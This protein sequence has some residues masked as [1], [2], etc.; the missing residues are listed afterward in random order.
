MLD[1]QGAIVKIDA[2]VSQAKIAKTITSKGGDYLLAIISHQ[3]KLA[4]AVQT[5]FT[6]PDYHRASANLSKR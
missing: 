2:M 5:A 1:L 4:A 3:E 6:S